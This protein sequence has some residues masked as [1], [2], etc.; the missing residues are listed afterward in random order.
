MTKYWN[1]KKLWRIEVKFWDSLVIMGWF[2]LSFPLYLSWF[3]DFLEK[4]TKF[5]TLNSLRCHNFVNFL[6]IS[7][8]WM[9]WK[10]L[11]ALHRSVFAVLDESTRGYKMYT[12]KPEHGVEYEDLLAGLL[13][14]EWQY[15]CVIRTLYESLHEVGYTSPYDPENRIFFSNGLEISYKLM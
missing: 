9:F 10:G 14:C 2:A 4:I 3:V 15:L 11:D 8:F 13:I 1:L 12:H 5:P 6:S 7:F